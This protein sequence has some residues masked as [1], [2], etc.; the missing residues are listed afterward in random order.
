MFGKTRLVLELKSES[1]KLNQN[2]GFFKLE[3]L[4]N[5]LRCEVKFLDETRWL[6]QLM[7]AFLHV[8]RNQQK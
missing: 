4:T 5:N 2:A 8:V 3:Y 7:V 6:L 1:L